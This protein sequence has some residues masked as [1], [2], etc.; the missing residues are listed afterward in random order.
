M[1]LLAGL[2]ALL[3]VAERPLTSAELA[4]LAETSPAVVDKGLAELATALATTAPR[5]VATD[6]VAWHAD[7]QVVDVRNPGEVVDGMVPGAQHVPLARLLDR[8]DE[9]DRD[10]PVVVYCANQQCNSSEEAAKKLE[11]AGF[12]DVSRYTGGAAEWQKEAEEVA[13]S[14]CC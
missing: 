4:E 3:F 10:V 5:L 9:L 7:A 2:E 12:T 6:A 8:M 1:S 14:D 13:A 11:A